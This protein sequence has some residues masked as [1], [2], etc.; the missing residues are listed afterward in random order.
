M[1]YKKILLGGR[2][3]GKSEIEYKNISKIFENEIEYAF[4]SKT[5]RYV[6]I[7]KKCVDDEEQ[8][9]TCIDELVNKYKIKYVVKIDNFI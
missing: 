6:I 9:K 5:N 7:S 3:N 2:W 8:L 1:L 4:I